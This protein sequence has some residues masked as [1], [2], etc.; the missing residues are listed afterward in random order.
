MKIILVGPTYPFRGGIAHYTTLLY[1]ALRRHH[2]VRLYSLVRQYPAWLYPGSNDRDTSSLP[3]EEPGAI[4]LL[5]PLNPVS[6]CR[7]GRAIARD[8]PD[9]VILPWW[10]PFWAPVFWVVIRFARLWANVPVLFV[11]HNVLPH[12]GSW[13]GTLLS[14]LALRQGDYFVVHSSQEREKLLQIVPSAQVK[15][16]PHPTYAVFRNASVTRSMARDKLGLSGD[17]VLFFGFVREYK[18]LRYLLQALQIALQE[19]PVTALVV[20]EF[21]EDVR[22]YEQFIERL[23]ISEHVRIVN[24]YVPNEEVSTY[25]LA[26]DLVVLPYVTATGSGV[27]QIALG[28][29]RP[30]IVTDLPGLAELVRDGETGF[31]V[32]PADPCLLAAAILRYFREADREQFWSNIASRNEEFSWAR[33][34]GVIESLAQR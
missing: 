32:P 29:E 13:F 23:G 24:A 4:P 25:F 34:V 1:R 19:R 21:W 7:V 26:A 17:V 3:I 16:S 20:G 30:L 5:D 14:R 2:Q 11:C 33:M 12:E 28:L 6:W 9:M 22:D 18:G 10:V 8:R 31:V 15:H 27:A